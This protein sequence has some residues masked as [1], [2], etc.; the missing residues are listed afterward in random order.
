MN[1]CKRGDARSIRN[2]SVSKHAWAH[3]RHTDHLIEMLASQQR[4]L[5]VHRAAC[6]LER[7]LRALVW[8]DG[9][10]VGVSRIFLMPRVQ[11]ASDKECKEYAYTLCDLL[12]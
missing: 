9:E 10:S 12:M 1:S 7:T 4:C 6:Q 8:Q 3:R 11:R 5:H 2:V